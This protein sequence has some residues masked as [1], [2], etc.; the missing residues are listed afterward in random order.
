MIEEYDYGFLDYDYYGIYSHDPLYVLMINEQFR[1]LRESFYSLDENTK[2]ILD[3]FVIRRKLSDN[4]DVD[5]D[6]YTETLK[7]A[8][9]DF[10]NI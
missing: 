5:I 9:F 8:Y 4:I 7:K 3:Y 2:N 10:Y 1:I 6:K